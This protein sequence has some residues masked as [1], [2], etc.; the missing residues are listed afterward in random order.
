MRRQGRTLLLCLAVMATSGLAV[1]DVILNPGEF[2][3]QV[4]FGSQTFSKVLLMLFSS[5]GQMSFKEF[6]A[7][8]YSMTVE[9]G[10]SYQH[11]MRATLT[12]PGGGLSTFEVNRYGLFPV[13]NQVGP[14]TVDYVYPAMNLINTS[15]TVTGG[16]LSRFEV[17]ATASNATE[18]LKANAVKNHGTPPVTSSSAVMA[19]VA[20]SQVTVTGKV[21]VVTPTGTVVQRALAAQV[22][23]LLAG[24]ANVSWTENL[25]ATGH[26]VGTV[27]IAPSSPVSFHE[28]YFQGV[29]G[30]G[31]ALVNG[32]RQVP[33]GGTYDLE[34]VP[35]QYDVYARTAI[36]SEG[37]YSDT[38]A[39]RV[40][41]T[42]GATLTQNFTD[43]VGTA[44]AP[45]VVTGL[46]SNADLSDADLSLK[47]QDASQVLETDAFDGALTN[48]RFDLTLPHG[49]WRKSQ[50]R[51]NFSNETHPSSPHYVDVFRKYDVGGSPPLTVPANSTVSFGTE[52]LTLVKT[53]LYFD[54]R[55]A[56]PT[57]PEIPLKLPSANLF[58]MHLDT[59]SGRQWESSAT[60]TGPDV[61]KTLA[62]LT[63]IAEPGTYHLNASAIVNGNYTEFGG[64]SMTVAEPTATPAGSNVSITPIS[65]QDLKV[66]VTFPSVTTGGL[67]TVAELPLGPEVPHG[68]KSFCTDGASAEGIDCAPLFY[69]IDTTAQFTEATVCVR[70]KFRGA[71]A[72]SLFLRLYHFNKDAPPSGQ[73]EELPAPPGRPQ[74]FDCSENPADCGCAS[75]AACGIDYNVDP[76]VSVIQICGVTTSFSPF[77]IFEKGLEFTNTVNGVEYQGPTG[78]PAPQTWT[79]PKTG[80]YRITATGASGASAVAGIPGG[81]GAKVS[82]VF[83]LQKNDTLQMLVGQMG[84]PATYSAG[85]G[86]GS[87]VAKSGSPLLI[88]GGGGGLRVGALV[89]G[90]SGS[91]S[92]SGTAGST[93][94]SYTSG[95]IAGGTGG[96]GGARAAGYGAGGGGWSGNGAADGTYG[97][98]GFAF[99][100]GGKGGAGKTCGGLAHGGYGGGGAGNGCYGGGGGGGYSGGGGGR[101]GGGGGSWNVGTQQEAVEGACTLN[102]HGKITIEFAHP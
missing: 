3:G 79:A 49:V 22:V 32:M 68:L 2:K 36:Q 8:P 93:N 11:T 34:L 59:S 46:Y 89:P 95:F 7:S 1:A 44:Q 24:P 71:N 28:V 29:V 74:A 60:S 52:T 70:R 14:T 9:S 62:A 27:S 67:T 5:T 18:S 53:T 26:L 19:M 61:N 100:S 81:C 101:V 83:S 39:Y 77:A 55:E 92:T 85:G 30:T 40:T 76:P 48:G 82:G 98:G 66:N 21:S 56:N 13:D 80:K 99:L 102:G 96:L 87:F 10:Q 73:W 84:T 45:L 15:V 51:L 65:N 35:G 90:R 41:I 20:M 43:P 57:D 23:N 54:V 16:T 38:K 72:L 91:T 50:L 86:G 17:T 25:P 75:E 6:T 63:V 88:A 64:G 47:R 12:H 37:Q 94:A 69:D 78:P 97:E 42:S 31:T 4:S 33:V 58:R